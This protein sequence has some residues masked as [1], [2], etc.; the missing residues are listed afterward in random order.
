MKQLL[1]KL[2]NYIV[3]PLNPF[4]GMCLSVVMMEAEG[5]ITLKEYSRLK[6]FIRLKG[7]EENRPLVIYW[8]LN[9]DKRPRLQWLDEKIAE[10]GA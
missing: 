3:D 7:K 5:E 10:L 4:T 8:W 2:K 9:G 6:N 1:I